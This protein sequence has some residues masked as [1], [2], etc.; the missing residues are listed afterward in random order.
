MLKKWEKLPDWM[1]TDEVRPYYDMLKKRRFSL[2][3]KRIFDILV[4]FFL[5]VLLSPVFAVT[6]IA[7]KCDS[8]GPV[9]FRQER[10]TKYGRIFRIHKFRSMAVNADKSGTLVTVKNDTRITRVGAVIRRLR[11]D[12][13]PQ[14]IDILAGNMTFVGT[15]PEV[16]K[17]VVTYTPEMMATLL[18]PAGLT[19]RISICY[20]DEDKLLVDSD[21][22]E[23]TYIEEILPSKMKWNLKDI[24]KFNLLRDINT[25]LM[26]AFAVLGRKFEFEDF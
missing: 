1:R 20:K 2:L 8:K 11:I 5:L 25:M 18:L 15:R 17:Y 9:F 6:A 22:P 21:N 26:T 7:I 24:K 3:C 14:L 10:V 16:E 23:K 4:S 19:S 12:E 13:L